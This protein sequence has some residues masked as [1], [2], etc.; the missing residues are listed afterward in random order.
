MPIRFHILKWKMY[1]LFQ[2]HVELKFHFSFLFFFCLCVFVYAT[3]WM[4]LF[5]IPSTVFFKLF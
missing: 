2:Q 3:K 1:G 4:P 5:M